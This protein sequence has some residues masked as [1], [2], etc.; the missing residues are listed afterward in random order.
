MKKASLIIIYGTTSGNTEMVVD[1]IAE[2]AKKAGHH[3][4]AKRVESAKPEEMLEYDIAILA[5]PT[6]GHGE[7][8]EDFIPFWRGMGEVD[9]KGKKCA[10]VGLGDPKYELHY[11]LESAPILEEAIQKSGGQILLPALKISGTPVRHLEGL[12]PNW[13]EKFINLIKS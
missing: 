7:L 11:H 8:Q 1:K 5:S 3:V 2:M 9:L 12:I 13:T 4:V 10:V 6:Y